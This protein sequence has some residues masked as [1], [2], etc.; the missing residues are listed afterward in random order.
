MVMQTNLI[1]FLPIL[2]GI[3]LLLFGFGIFKGKMENRR[4]GETS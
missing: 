2:I 1:G 4:V 3:Q